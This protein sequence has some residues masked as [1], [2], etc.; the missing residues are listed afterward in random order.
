MGILLSSDIKK[1]TLKNRQI[2][3]PNQYA[4]PI[5]PFINLANGLFHIAYEITTRARSSIL[6]NYLLSLNC[7]MSLVIFGISLSN[8]SI[9]PNCKNG[10]IICFIFFMIVIS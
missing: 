4:Y 2:W 1:K 5:M 7:F 10:K 8:Q 6:T 9:N 3:G